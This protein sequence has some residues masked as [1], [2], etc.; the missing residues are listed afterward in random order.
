MKLVSERSSSVAAA[1]PSE[2]AGTS[3]HRNCMLQ[4]MSVFA[5]ALRRAGMTFRPDF[6]AHIL[7]DGAALRRLEVRVNEL[8]AG[9]AEA[10]E[11]GLFLN[12]FRTPM[13]KTGS[14]YDMERL[15]SALGGLIGFLE[16]SHANADAH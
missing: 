13:S 11:L 14:P 3:A 16:A 7:K 8:A 6:L 2:S 1:F 10:K 5:G 12:R 9:T 15:E 4:A